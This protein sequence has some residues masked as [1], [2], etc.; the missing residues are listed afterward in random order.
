MSDIRA[1]NIIVVAKGVRPDRY[2]NMTDVTNR[3]VGFRS[4]S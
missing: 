4:E 3:N 1:K 2:E